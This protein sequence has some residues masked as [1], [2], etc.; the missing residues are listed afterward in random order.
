MV[1]EENWK[2]LLHFE[3]VKVI[4]EINGIKRLSLLWKKYKEGTNNI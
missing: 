4:E 2:N 1:K 3:T